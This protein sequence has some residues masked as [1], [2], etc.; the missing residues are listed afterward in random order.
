ML[1]F[2]PHSDQQDNQKVH[3]DAMTLQLLALSKP[4]IRWSVTKYL[5]QIF[6]FISPPI[7]R[8]R[9]QTVV[10]ECRDNTDL[11]RDSSCQ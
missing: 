2:S 6:L 10:E 3:G 1:T 7:D 4:L 11:L 9:S 5:L 8:G